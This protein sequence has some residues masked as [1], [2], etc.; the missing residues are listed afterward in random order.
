MLKRYIFLLCLAMSVSGIQ[1]QL[2]HFT[3][4]FLTP[5]ALNPALTGSFYGTVRVNGVVRDQDRR[6]TEPNYEYQSANA[7]LD[8]NI[9]I[10]FRK[11]DWTSVGFNFG[12]VGAGVT[13][14]VRNEISGSAAYHISMDKKEYRVLS[15]GLA[16]TNVSN[17]VSNS[18]LSDFVDEKFLITGSND[19]ISTAFQNASPDNGRLSQAKSDYGLG[20]VYTAPMGRSADIRVGGSIKQVIRP[21]VGILAE[22]QDKLD[23]EFTAFV[24]FY[25]EINRQ[26]TLIPTLLYSTEG[27][28]SHY[29]NMGAMMSYQL[30]KESDIYLNGGLGLRTANNSQDLLVLTGIDWKLWRFGLA[31][32]TN[33]GRVANTANGFGALELGVSKIIFVHKKP[34]VSPVLLCPRL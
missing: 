27:I 14:F 22:P 34:K 9:D 12:R 6:P 5:L 15:I 10:A 11:Q 7:S 8:Y 19:I 26:L 25:T 3:Q 4:D 28:A 23:P 33:M 17:S 32:D 21:R 1:A 24:K 30:A 29:L 31:F 16:F 18:N 2:V 13:N 20:V